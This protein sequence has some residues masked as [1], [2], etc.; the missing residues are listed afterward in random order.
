MYSA[1]VAWGWL[2][3]ATLGVVCTVGAGE[4]ALHTT[5]VNVTIG[6]FVWFSLHEAR[7]PSNIGR[8]RHG[9]YAAAELRAMGA[10]GRL[11]GVA[12]ERVLSAAGHR[13]AA[14]PPLP[15][16]LTAREAEVLRLLTLGLTTRQVAER[17]VISPKTA[18]HHVQHIYTKIGVS[19]PRRHRALRHRTRHPRHRRV[20]RQA[21]RSGVIPLCGRRASGRGID[22]ALV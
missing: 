14:R 22:R 20:T 15:A 3:A 1:G 12:V 10:A 7:D 6:T 16:G 2:A 11:D 19:N 4:Y 9:D 8:C 13:R 5:W 17:L 18:D 21:V